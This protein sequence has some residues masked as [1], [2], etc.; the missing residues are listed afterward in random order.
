MFRAMTS[1]KMS[2]MFFSK[3]LNMHTPYTVD[4]A[5]TLKRALTSRNA[6]IQYRCTSGKMFY[7]AKR[8][9]IEVMAK[10]YV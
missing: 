10:S 9:I 2:C 3:Y 6:S 7:E 4:A 1:L 5:I 8:L